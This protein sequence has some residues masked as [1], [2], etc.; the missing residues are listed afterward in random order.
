M[1]VTSVLT[2]YRDVGSAHS[3]SDRVDSDALVH[4]RHLQCDTRHRESADVSVPSH[5][6][7]EGGLQLFVISEIFNNKYANVNK[8]F[9]KLCDETLPLI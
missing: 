3:F 1:L 6:D 8:Y 2:H 5:L 7:L 4:S 9:G